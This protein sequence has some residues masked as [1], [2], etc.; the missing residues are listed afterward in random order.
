[1]EI[2]VINEELRL[3]I[4]KNAPVNEIRD[5]ALRNGMNTLAMSA[6]RKVAEGITSIE[7]M[8]AI[9]MDH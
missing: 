8:L 7:Q 4:N 3:L 5:A 6:M 1:M 9:T 2:M